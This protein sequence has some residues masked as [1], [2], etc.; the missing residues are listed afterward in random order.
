MV[1]ITAF[2]SRNFLLEHR[3]KSTIGYSSKTGK[4]EKK[5]KE[6]GRCKQYKESG[7]KAIGL[8]FKICASNLFITLCINSINANTMV[9]MLPEQQIIHPK[10]YL[11][12][13]VI[14]HLVIFSFIILG[15]TFRRELCGW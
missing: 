3:T 8:V 2:S 14:W 12:N 7:E 10:S 6:K 9:T 15:F 4:T 1:I 5:E 11:G 13:R